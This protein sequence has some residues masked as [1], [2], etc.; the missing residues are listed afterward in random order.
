MWHPPVER[1][2]RLPPFY[3]SHLAPGIG[4]GRLAVGPGQEGE[5]RLGEE[6]GPHLQ[7]L[8]HGERAAA[9]SVNPN[10]PPIHMAFPTINSVIRD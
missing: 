10:R 5:D 1:H 6:R 9:L 2:V 4:T 8:R 7:G 3:T